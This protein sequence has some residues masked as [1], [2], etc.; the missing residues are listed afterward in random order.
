MGEDRALDQV[1]AEDEWQPGRPVPGAMQWLKDHGDEYAGEWVAIGPR[2][3]VA[4]GETFEE[5]ESQLPSLRGVLIMQ[6]V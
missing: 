6:L 5:M 4:H 2:G 3:L 1:Q